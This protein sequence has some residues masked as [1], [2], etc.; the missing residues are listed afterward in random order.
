MLKVSQ[1]VGLRVFAPK[2]PKTQKDGT[3][4]ERLQRLGKVHNAVFSP[5]GRS[6]VGLLV[7]RPDVVGIIKRDDAFVALDSFELAPD[8][9]VT[10]TRPED[11]LDDAAIRRLSLDWDACII[12][13]GMDAKTTEGKPLG[14]VSDAEFSEK[15][16]EVSRF[17]STDG[18]VAHALLGS[19]VI[20]PD[21]LRGYR[22]GCMIVDAGGRAVEL[23]G[24]LAGAAGEGYA[25]AKVK[26]AEVG[27]K[28]GAA[29]GEAVDK[30]S[31]ALGKMIGKAQRAIKDAT[32]EGEKD[33]AAPQPPAMEAADVR[34]TKP[35]EGLPERAAEEPADRSAPKTYRPAPEQPAPAAR[36]AQK[37][38][39]KRQ[40]PKKKPNTGDKIARAAGKQLGSLGKMLG[41]FKDEFDKAS[42]G[43]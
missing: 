29:A 27:K 43:E 2:K 14:Y 33:E 8:G 17:S 5:D 32:E 7:K 37:A 35:A 11:G 41:S 24:G 18:G 4:T 1:L 13:S 16:G 10:V 23:D 40:A 6:V 9:T 3:I 20:T 28:V 30:G 21:M 42:K 19:F 38:S 25:R 31:F 36:P 22:D 12:W 26:G 34:V 15:T 39:P